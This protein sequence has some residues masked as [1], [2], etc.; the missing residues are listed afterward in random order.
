MQQERNITPSDFFFTG[1]TMHRKSPSYVIRPADQ[2]LF[3]RVLAGQFCYVLTPRQMGKSSLVVRTAQRLQKEGIK[4]VDI[5]LQGVGG[6]DIVVDQ[7]YQT[8]LDVIK[9][10]LSLPVSPEIWWQEHA[11]LSPVRRFTTY[12]RDVVLAEVEGQVVIFIDEIDTTLYLDFRDDFFAA[13]RAMHNARATDPT[14]RRLTCVLLGVVSPSDLIKDSTISP[15]NIGQRIDLQEFELSNASV[16]QEGLEKFHP[17]QGETIF[18]CIYNWTNGHP[19]LTQKLCLAAADTKNEHW[20]ENQVDELVKQLFLSTEVSE[21]DHLEL[22]EK[23]I[24]DNDRRRD[25]LKLYEQVYQGKEVSDDKQSILQNQ[26]KLSGLIK[27][28]KGYLHVRNKIY[29]HVF[30]SSWIQEN[31]QHDWNRNLAFVAVVLAVF[32]GVILWYNNVRVPYLAEKAELDFHRAYTNPEERVINLATLFELRGFFGASSYDNK[33][34]ELFFGLQTSQ[35]QFALFD[36]K[37]DKIVIVIKGLYVTLADVDN[38]NRTGPLLQTML[39]AL[40][41]L[42][43]TEETKLLKTEISSWVQGRTLARQ[44]NFDAAQIEYDKAISIN[45]DNPATLYERAKVETELSEYQLALNDL[46][47][48]IVI[49]GRLATPTP[50]T[51]AVTI[52]P[53]LEQDQGD[54]TD[55][56][57]TP[58]APPVTT[59]EIDIIS[60]ISPVSTNQIIVT[61]TETSSATEAPSS[62]ATPTPVKVASEFASTSQ[63]ISA[64]RELIDS[65]PNLISYLL[66]VSPQEF[67]NLREFGLVPTPTSTPQPTEESPPETLPEPVI[68][69]LDGPTSINPSETFRVDVVAKNVPPPGLY[70]IQFEINY[71]PTLISASNLQIN[72][73]LSFVVRNTVDNTIGKITLVASQQGKVPGLTGNVTLL[74]FDAT[75]ANISEIA[76]FTFGNDKISNS[77]AQ[78]VNN[79]NEDHAIAI[80]EAVAPE[81]TDTPTPE[82]TNEP[83]FEPT[84]EPT[85]EPADESTS[86][87]VSGQVILVGRAGDD[88]SGAIVT[89]N[90]SG[91][92]G[93]TDA[94]GNFSI[95]NPT[96]GSFDSITVDAPG[97]LSAVCTGVKVDA[98]ETVMTPVNLLSGDINGD[99]FVDVTDATAV[100]AGFGQTG[101]NLPADITRDGILDIFDIVLVSVNF[102]EEGPQTWSCLDK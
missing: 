72:P 10:K 34:Q 85:P 67:S 56:T 97:Y 61:S 41:K 17:R 76:S 4:T 88:W 44:G 99:N 68:L 82:P 29:R 11:S 9:E 96:T 98:L 35:E 16:L 53:S 92:V 43:E 24:L 3:N 7:W 60:P 33:A 81:P 1:G 46:D 83:T 95:A 50:T 89:I 42:D 19:Y 48:V 8:L 75:A 40:E 6:K 47:Q 27:A 21:E 25:L 37:S 51:S 20:T 5:D 77:Q 80:G 63:I 58:T 59:P 31:T 90:D 49:G 74:S 93:T 84:E 69:T 54:I 26:L 70:G 18:T 78:G 65:N 100:G 62:T 36:V 15:F 38:T 13:I 52:S 39:K 91:Q 101:S 102:G 23:Q 87:K 30:N 28:E 71:D 12:L 2:E 64:V 66:S 14:F 73:N 57:S 94:T 79:V 32:L 22:V 45:G 86:V 55:A